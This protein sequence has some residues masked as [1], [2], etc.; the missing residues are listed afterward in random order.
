MSAL[1]VSIQAQILNLLTDL[2]AEFGLTYVF[3]AHDLS[4]VRHVS[5]RVEVMY[6]G[7]VVERG[8]VGDIYR[9]PRHPYSAALLAAVPVPDPD[10]VDHKPRIVLTGDLPSPIHPPLGCRFNSRCP[11]ATDLCRSEEPMLQPQLGDPSGHVAACHYPL[12]DG[13]TLVAT[14]TGTGSQTM[15]FGGAAPSEEGRK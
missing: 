10:Y 14:S 1:D 13:E 15:S 3:I 6:L 9:S 2:Q 11:R 8:P 4:V 12:A 7:K 5:D